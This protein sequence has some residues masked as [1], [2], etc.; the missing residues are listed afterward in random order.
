MGDCEV[1]IKD[2]LESK[3]IDNLFRSSYPNANP[4]K[5]IV[6]S[7]LFWPSVSQKSFKVPEEIEVFQRKFTEHFETLKRSRKLEWK[8]EIGKVLFEIEFADGKVKEYTTTPIQAS[9]I[10]HFQE[11]SNRI[12]NFRYYKSRNFILQIKSFYICSTRRNEILVK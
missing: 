4:V 8:Q 9:I 10:Y 1:M 5:S 2:V 11:A 12:C 7:Y 6:T 3:R